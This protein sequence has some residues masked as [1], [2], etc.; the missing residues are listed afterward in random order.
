MAAASSGSR[1]RTLVILGALLLGV[2]GLLGVRSA[3]P[4]LPP[5]IIGPV[6]GAPAA[7]PASDNCIDTTSDDPRHAAA[8]LPCPDAD[9]ARLAEQL[10]AALPRTDV[11]EVDGAYARL[12]SRSLVVGFVDDV[13]LFA[14]DEVVHV[15][16]A[17][18]LGRSDLGVNR[19]RVEELRA[20]SERAAACR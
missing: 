11:V 13:E 16:S 20:I 7:C 14:D 3:V 12:R 4:L 15:R 9:L 6:D 17:A 8:P 5:P 18:R 10:A 19:D 1:R 2:L